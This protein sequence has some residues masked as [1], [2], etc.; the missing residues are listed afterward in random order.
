MKKPEQL[1]ATRASNYMKINHS[2][3][4]YRFDIAADVPLPISLAKRN[5]ELQGKWSKGYPDMFIAKCNKGFGGLY[6]ELKATKTLV[7]SSHT[8]RQKVVHQI[9]RNAGYKVEFAFGYDHFIE[10]VTDY[11]S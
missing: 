11:L 10:I 8:D 1:L 5:K 4:I 9:L 2:S 3:I 6:I 7:K